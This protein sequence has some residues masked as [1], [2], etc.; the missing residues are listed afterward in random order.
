MHPDIVTK[1]QHLELRERL[2]SEA[3][4]NA[5][6]SA[7]LLPLYQAMNKARKELQDYKNNYIPKNK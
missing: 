2:A 1:L 4:I 5:P 6:K 7:R 3:F